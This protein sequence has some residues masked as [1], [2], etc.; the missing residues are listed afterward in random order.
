MDMTSSENDPDILKAFN[1]SRIRARRRRRWTVLLLSALTAALAVYGVM[2]GNG[3]DVVQYRTQPAVRG[4][5][6]VTVTATGSLAAVNSV[7]VGSELSGTVRY[8]DVTYNDRVKKGQV[9]AR[10]DTSKLQAQVVQS[11]ASHESAQARLLQV[12]ATVKE[13]KA[14]LA[15]L[16]HLREISN[17]KGVSRHD[18]DAAEADLS[19]ALADEAYYRAE[20]SRTKG[21]LDADETDLSKTIVRSPIN[22]IVLTRSVEPGQ[23]VAAAMTT[24]ILFTLAED[25]AKMELQLDVDEADVGEVREGQQATFTVDAYQERRFPARITQVRY[26]AKTKN[27]VVTYKAI[28]EVDNSELLL[29]PG[30]TATAEIT[31]NRV[32][33]AILVPNAALRFT[34]PRAEKKD[35]EREGGIMSKILPHPPPPPGKKNAD[36][37]AAAKGKHVWVLRDGEPAAVPIK[38]GPTDGA[39]T[40]VREGAIEPDMAVLVDT[41]GVKR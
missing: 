7:E 19:R 2:T 28:L 17:E 16:K 13:K 11:R 41:A 23:T 3:G 21:V 37:E 10:L 29:R 5:L 24:P 18:L 27:S 32:E 8:V 6:S 39:F 4:S 15:R 33:N 36:A 22:G 12:Q 20:V 1:A 40:V 14:E 31:V 30:M 26:G 34:P 9:L 25:L 35:N 38:T